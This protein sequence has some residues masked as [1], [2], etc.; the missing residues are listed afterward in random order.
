[1]LFSVIFTASYRSSGSDSMPSSCLSSSVIVYI[2][3]VTCFGSLYFFLM[4]S[5]PAASIT[6]KARYGLH[7]GS[8]FLSSILVAI[9]LPGLYIGTLTSADLFLCAHE[10]YTGASYPGTS[11][12]YEL[13]H[14][15][16]TEHI[17]VACFNN[18]AIK[19]FAVSD[20]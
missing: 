6:E 8:G 17:S 1:M 7:A 18:P 2:L 11:L 19:Y 5:N 16:H 13:T 15:Q 14:W 9:S 12:L 3:F 4:P 10:T 20:K